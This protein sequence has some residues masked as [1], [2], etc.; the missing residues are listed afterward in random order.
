[1]NK[2]AYQ[3]IKI[4]AGRINVDRFRQII[5][6]LIRYQIDKIS[7]GEQQTI[8]YQG[9]KENELLSKS[10]ETLNFSFQ[11]E[12]NYNLVSSIPALDILAS[13][14]WIHAGVYSKIAQSFPKIKPL[15]V[16][17]V[18]PSQR[19]VSLFGSQVNFIASEQLNFWYL[20]IRNLDGTYFLW[21]VMINSN[22]VGGTYQILCELL[23][24]NIYLDNKTLVKLFNQ[25]NVSISTRNYLEQPKIE[26]MEF[27]YFDGLH[28]T[29][30]D[31][32]FGFS[33]AK[34]YFTT[35]ELDVFFV[36]LENIKVKEIYINL[37]GGLIIKGIDADKVPLLNQWIK[38]STFKTGRAF[39]ELGWQFDG[40]DLKA[41]NLKNGFSKQLSERGNEN[42]GFSLKLI[43]KNQLNLFKEDTDYVIA[44]SSFLPFSSIFDRYKLYIKK[45]KNPLDGIYA[46]VGYSQ[47]Y[48]EIVENLYTKLKSEST[49]Q[50]NNFILEQEEINKVESNQEKNT[51]LYICEEC[52]TIYDPE[53]GDI[54][55]G[56]LPGT[57]FKFL[58]EDYA[59]SVCGAHKSAIKEIQINFN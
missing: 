22:S 57:D 34:G 37:R 36:L 46:Q 4:K 43:P 13:S 48:E 11:T 30:K 15:S 35:K 6:V 28:Y 31:Y 51:Q 32:W 54:N 16:R 21:P 23:T 7:I 2:L 58:P 10:I 56:I 20:Y 47:S 53:I 50:I 42:Y 3:H 17:V 26:S 5:K 27:P 49:L 44:Y 41:Y 29:G 8:Y 12:N 40:L 1:M 24:N 14:H 52:D 25:Q 33:G 19:L 59:C 55:Q 38:R 9:I 18:D 39:N 45:S